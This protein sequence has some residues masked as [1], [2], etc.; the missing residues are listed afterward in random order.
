MRSPVPGNCI[1]PR[2]ARF[3][4]PL[5]STELMPKSAAT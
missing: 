2:A 3:L 5:E 1:K 4:H